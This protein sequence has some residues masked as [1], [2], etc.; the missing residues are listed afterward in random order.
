MITSEINSTDHK[1]TSACLFPDEGFREVI[2]K[3]VESER[4]YKRP[5][6]V[7]AEFS[8]Y[9]GFNKSVFI[10]FGAWNPLDP[11]NTKTF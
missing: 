7:E 3:L 5:S 2:R 4:E 9:Y 6:D 10:V 8:R 1:S 11:A